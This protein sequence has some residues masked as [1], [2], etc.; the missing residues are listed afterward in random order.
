MKTLN[1]TQKTNIM[2]KALFI[3]VAI[4]T[5]SSCSDDDF[6]EGPIENIINLSLIENNVR[7]PIFNNGDII[8]LKA[9]FNKITEDKL[10]MEVVYREDTGILIY[11]NTILNSGDI[12]VI[13]KNELI[14]NAVDFKFE[15]NLIDITTEK[16]KAGIYIGV[17]NNTKGNNYSADM[18]TWS[19]LNN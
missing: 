17:I 18:L 14:N 2:K 13:D 5:L 3:L 1:L 6:Y 12:F 11:N 4:L 9:S 8:L 19:I 16:A 15:T 7:S 10:Y